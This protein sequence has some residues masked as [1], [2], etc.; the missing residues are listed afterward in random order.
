MRCLLEHQ[1]INWE[2]RPPRLQRWGGWPLRVRWDGEVSHPGP[3]PGTPFGGERPTILVLPAGRSASASPNREDMAADSA[4]AALI[5]VGSTAPCRV[6]YINSHLAGT[7]QGVAPPEWLRTHGRQRCRICRRSIF[8][9]IRA[10]PTCSPEAH[11]AAIIGE[12]LWRLASKCYIVLV[13]DEAREF[14]PFQQRFQT[15]WTDCCHGVFPGVGY[16]VLW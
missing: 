11:V 12:I 2:R 3:A 10:P 8:H 16:L 14:F 9:Q 1:R 6:A 13:P 15:Y 4:G 7:L 5:R